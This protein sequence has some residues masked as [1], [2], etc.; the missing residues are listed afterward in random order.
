MTKVI[1]TDITFSIEWLA[2]TPANSFVEEVN[3]YPVVS[4]DSK[5]KT[6]WG[7]DFGS[8][9]LKTDVNLTGINEIVFNDKAEVIGVV[10]PKTVK[11]TNKRTPASTADKFNTVLY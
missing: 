5:S 7:V 9:I 3:K 11:G 10:K 2:Q 4:L 1:K 8:V 6:P